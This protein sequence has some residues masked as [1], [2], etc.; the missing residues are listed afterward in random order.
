MSWSRNNQRLKLQ[1]M[2]GLPWLMHIL[3][4]GDFDSHLSACACDKA[5]GLLELNMQVHAIIEGRQF[6]TSSWLPLSGCTQHRGSDG[7]RPLWNKGGRKL[8][9]YSWWAP[10]RMFAHWVYRWAGSSWFFCFLFTG[11]SGISSDILFGEVGNICVYKNKN[12]KKSIGILKKSSY[13]PTIFW[14]LHLFLF[15]NYFLSVAFLHTL[16]GHSIEKV[17]T[18]SVL[19]FHNKTCDQEIAK[20]FLS[21]F[22]FFLHGK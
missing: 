2:Y 3:W 9:S 6:N 12:N 21:L 15:K 13:S 10:F 16:K 4:P 8:E 20:H 22:D 19:E 14:T 18:M 7:H 5:A 11:I 17:I 1:R